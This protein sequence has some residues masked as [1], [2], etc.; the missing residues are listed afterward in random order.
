MKLINK[1]IYKELTLPIIFG[2]S[3]F[4]FIFLIDILV[5]M[6]E[7]ILVKSVPVLDVLE[8]LS[9][10]LP[11]IFAE[12]IPMGV[13]LGIM[14]TFS[15]LSTTS[16]IIAMES[17]GISLKKIIR[18]TFTL[19]F[20]IMCFVYFLYQ[21][22]IP[23]SGEKLIKISRKI[24]Y[25]KPSVQLEEKIF[26]TGINDYNVYINH[27]EPEGTVADSLVI[28]KKEIDTIYPQVILAKKAKW[29]NSK[30]YLKNATFYK[31]SSDGKISLK[32][33]FE[34]Q[35]VP[36]NTFFGDF[37]TTIEKPENMSISDLLKK[38]NNLKKQNKKT[39][40][41]E[42]EMYKKLYTPSSILILSVLGVILSVNNNRTGKGASFGISILII[43]I[44]ITLINIFYMISQK[45]NIA[46][47]IAMII[48]NILL[49]LLTMFLYVKKARSR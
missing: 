45:G 37:N 39:I 40:K 49:L 15:S 38:I 18:P 10:T 34:K 11:P 22:V 41:Y 1:Y 47:S 28:F 33:K 43:F 8:L 21:S 9:Y 6:M 13:F 30:M 25:T 3:L 16:E 32:G 7:N 46:P 5:S 35:E 14:I 48:P 26:V 36:I 44:Y 29:E 17:I 23:R 31:V 19:S 2:I 27:L 42:L 20:I 24:A 12:T 4:T